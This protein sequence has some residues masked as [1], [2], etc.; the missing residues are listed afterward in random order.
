MKSIPV[1]YTDHLLESSV[2]F[3]VV[4]WSKTFVIAASILLILSGL[5]GSTA[6]AQGSFSSPELP[7]F[8]ESGGHSISSDFLA[9]SFIFRSVAFTS[10]IVDILRSNYTQSNTAR[11]CFRTF[12]R[13]LP[14]LSTTEQSRWAAKSGQWRGLTFNTKGENIILSNAEQRC[15]QVDVA[16]AF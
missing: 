13:N 1:C 11:S 2:S 12:P 7:D 6:L 10:S 8:S 14:T 16:P 15:P 3:D 5:A 4:R 9:A